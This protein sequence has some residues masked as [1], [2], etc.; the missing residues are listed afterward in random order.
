[1]VLNP[2]HADNMD[3]HIESALI[4]VCQSTMNNSPL[5]LSLKMAGIA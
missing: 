3:S 2:V 5:G 1:M 4:S